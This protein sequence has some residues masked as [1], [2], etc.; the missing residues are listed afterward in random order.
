MI[1]WN[2]KKKNS[3]GNSNFGCKQCKALIWLRAVHLTIFFFLACLT[4]FNPIAW[5]IEFIHSDCF[6]QFANGT[7]NN[8]ST[9]A[10]FASKY[11]VRPKQWRHSL[12]KTFT[13]N[14]NG[15]KWFSVY[16]FHLFQFTT[17]DSK[18]K[19]EKG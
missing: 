14:R 9:F 19:M 8:H 2:K 17:C 6:W 3:T 4:K 1:S 11:K 18:K 15:I 5:P 12:S 7:W 10:K 13:Y 16:A